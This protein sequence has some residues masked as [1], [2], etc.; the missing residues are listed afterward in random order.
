[1]KQTSLLKIALVIMGEQAGA[2]SAQYIGCVI[3]SVEIMRNNGGNL[4]SKAERY[5]RT[6][7]SEA[8]LA[9]L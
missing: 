9:A 8:M 2:E 1:M 4:Q 6:Q 7:L 3:S 5:C